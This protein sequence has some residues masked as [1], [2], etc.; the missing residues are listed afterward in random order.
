MIIDLIA[1]VQKYCRK[2]KIKL[3]LSPVE[4]IFDGETTCAGLFQPEIKTLS[5]AIRSPDWL[6]TLCHEYGHA[7]QYVENIFF[8]DASVEA[9]E[10]WQA[11]MDGETVCL[12]AARTALNQVI[13]CERDAEV[14]AQ[15]LLS[16]Y[17]VDGSVYAQKANA[18]LL[19]YAYSFYSHRFPSNFLKAQK[20]MPLDILVDPLREYDSATSKYFKIFGR[21]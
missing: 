10:T 21:L 13:A 20:K 9:G 18:H 4:A 2:N 15:G 1:E 3:L 6:E 19:A 17:G 16:H 7:Q 8:D 14:R 11:Y 12:D 5:V